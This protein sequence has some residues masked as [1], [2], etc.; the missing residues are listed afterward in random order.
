LKN[1]LSPLMEQVENWHEEKLGHMEGHQ[2]QKFNTC[3]PT[4]WLLFLHPF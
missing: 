2:I 3:E 4:K 1:L